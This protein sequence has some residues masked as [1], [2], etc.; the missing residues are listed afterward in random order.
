MT[1]AID[2]GPTRRRRPLTH[3]AAIVAELKAHASEI[4]EQGVT[5]LALFGSRVRGEERQ[6]SDLDVLIEYASDRPFTLYDL[7]RVE[8]LLKG[9]TGLEV[10]IAT[11]DG[12]RPHRLRRVLRDAI[13]VL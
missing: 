7:V 4:R 3:R 13:N 9:L 12:F 2:Q 11:R 10:H 5:S 6:D 1:D 8:R